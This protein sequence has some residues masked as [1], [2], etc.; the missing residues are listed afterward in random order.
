MFLT[1]RRTVHGRPVRSIRH[2]L[3]AGELRKAGKSRL[4]PLALPFPVRDAESGSP[5]QEPR[6][7]TPP[8]NRRADRAGG[9]AGRSRVGTDEGVPAERARPMTAP[10]RGTRHLAAIEAPD[11]SVPRRHKPSAAAAPPEAQPSMGAP[12]PRCSSASDDGTRG[13]PPRAP[14][15]VAARSRPEARWPA[16][17]RW[18]PHVRSSPRRPDLHQSNGG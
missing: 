16:R 11:R 14:V 13:R 9:V 12:P 2:V 18:V 10:S 17:E 5:V 1:G 3:I 6:R 7:L 8:P 4:S 15:R